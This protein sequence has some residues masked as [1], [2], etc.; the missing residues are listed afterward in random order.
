[1][2]AQ[3]I[4]LDELTRGEGIQNYAKF[5]ASGI[6]RHNNTI[7]VTPTRGTTIPLEVYFSHMNVKRPPNTMFALMPVKGMEVAAAYETAMDAALANDR[8]PFVFTCEDDNILAD[9]SFVKLLAAIWTCIDCGKGINPET[10]QCDDGHHGLDG[11]SGLYFM[12]CDP[13]VPMA[14]GDPAVGDD[15]VPR[16]IGDAIASGSVLE[17]NGIAMGCSLWRKA[18]F[19]DVPKPWFRTLSGA[20]K[21]RLGG[22]TQDLYFCR[23]A[24]Q[25]TAARFAVHCGVL[26]GHL[27]TATGRVF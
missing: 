11:V 14:F 4:R 19:A 8:F 27:D 1:M 10:W 16:E 21:A 2:T 15:M 7:W 20:E 22:Y 17:V 9:D 24:K 12:K 13:P 3:V 5:A 26:S 23:K 25:T 6:Y 18:A